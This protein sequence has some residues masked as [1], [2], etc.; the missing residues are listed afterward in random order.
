MKNTLVL[1]LLFCIFRALAEKF[2]RG[3]LCF[4]PLTKISA[5]AHAAKSKTLIFKTMQDF[6]F[7]DWD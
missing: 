5:G 1:N 7:Q 3:P 2:N 6:Y 4:A